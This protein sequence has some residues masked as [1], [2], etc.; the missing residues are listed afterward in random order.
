MHD[1]RSVRRL[2]LCGRMPPRSP[3]KLGVHD[4]GQALELA[5]HMG[6]L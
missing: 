3:F 2:H 1:T 5:R 4:R 6:V